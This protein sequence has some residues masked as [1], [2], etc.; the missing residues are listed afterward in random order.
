LYYFGRGQ[1][2]VR[3]AEAMI[4][5]DERSN[6]EFYVA[7]VYNRMIAAGMDVRINPVDEVWSLGTPEDLERFLREHPL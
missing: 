3:H 7:P 2:F 6:R 1:D 5:A 4:A